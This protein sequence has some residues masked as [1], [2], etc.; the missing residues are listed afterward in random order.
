[1]AENEGSD[2]ASESELLDK[3]LSVWKGKSGVG[4]EKFEPIPLDLHTGS[5]LGQYE[6]VKNLITRY[7]QHGQKILSFLKSA[8]SCSTVCSESDAS[9]LYTLLPHLQ[10]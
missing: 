8:I 3:S 2:E 10:G 6:C 4:K 7:V 1:M 9:H 5:S